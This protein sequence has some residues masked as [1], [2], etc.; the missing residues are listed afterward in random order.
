M[1][2]IKELKSE[3]IRWKK[4]IPLYNQVGSCLPQTKIDELKCKIN[5]IKARKL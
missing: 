1:E 5:Q 3:I 4:A 2:T